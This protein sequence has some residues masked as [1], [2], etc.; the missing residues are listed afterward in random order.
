MLVCHDSVI[1]SHGGKVASPAGEPIVARTISTAYPGERD[2]VAAFT[3]EAELRSTLLRG[4]SLSDAYGSN[5]PGLEEASAAL[6]Q[7]ML[8]SSK[9]LLAPNPMRP[10]PLLKEVNRRSS[11]MLALSSKNMLSSRHLLAVEEG[12]QESPKDA[13]PGP[14]PL[15]KAHAMRCLALISHNNMKGES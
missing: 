3:S 11:K 6:S 1:A 9:N 5:D 10:R 7:K 14:G 2:S 4:K 8:G 15:L 13:P 12:S